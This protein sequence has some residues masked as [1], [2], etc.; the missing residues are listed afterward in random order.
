MN[1]DPDIIYMKKLKLYL[2]F[3][4]KVNFSNKIYISMQLKECEQIT[5]YKAYVGWGNNHQIIK[6]CLKNRFWIELVERM[7]D[8]DVCFYWTPWPIQGLHNKQ[9]DRDQV[10]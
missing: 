4:F 6:Y 1:A 8:S 5:K 10:I 9:K 2:D 3:L 7:E